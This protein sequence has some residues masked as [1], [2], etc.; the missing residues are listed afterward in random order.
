V[1]LETQEKIFSSVADMAESESIGL[2]QD[3]AGINRRA[4]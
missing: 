3:K 2:S 4:V 1:A